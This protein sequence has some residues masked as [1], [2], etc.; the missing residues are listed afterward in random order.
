MTWL[1]NVL[2]ALLVIMSALVGA[3]YF[4][5]DKIEVQQTMLLRQSPEEVYPYLNNPTEWQHWSVLNKTN[6]PSMIHLYGGPLQGKGAR[7]Q[8]SGDKVGNGQL[9]F[10]ESV[11]PSM[12]IYEQ[13]LTDDSAS[14]HG[15]FTLASVSG[16]TQVSWSQQTVL[17]QTPIAK[18]FGLLQ[19]HKMEQEVIQGLQGL[20]TLLQNKGKK[21]GK[22]KF[23]SL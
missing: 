11:E 14:I 16:G 15:S 5:P 19:K 9:V 7:L 1:R 10:K 13:I 21:A 4:L 6:D 18:F 20:H 23:G 22:V 3:S 2:I 12:I 17:K 8:W